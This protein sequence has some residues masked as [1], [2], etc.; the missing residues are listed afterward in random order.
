MIG[1]VLVEIQMWLTY[2]WNACTVILVTGYV[3]TLIVNDPMP[4]FAL[5]A[6]GT[7]TIAFVTELAT[8]HLLRYVWDTGFMFIL[9]YTLASYAANVITEF[10]V[11]YA[12]SSFIILWILLAERMKI[13][14]YQPNT[15][16]FV[17][18]RGAL[19]AFIRASFAYIERNV[20]AI[21]VNHIRLITISIPTIETMGMCVLGDNSYA[22]DRSHT[23]PLTY[24]L[25]KSSIFV[26]LPI[27]ESEILLRI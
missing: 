22:Y 16:S 17:F 18:T 1:T 10:L 23:L 14:H 27:L 6:M 25:L 24:A 8:P 3:T 20:E 12:C 26:F 13:V 5:S 9:M 7:S 11:S 21:T 2:V 4:I 19:Y 15:A